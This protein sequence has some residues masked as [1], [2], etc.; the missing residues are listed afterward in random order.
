ML[1]RLR[2][3]GRRTE[4]QQKARR[5]AERTRYLTDNKDDTAVQMGKAGHL[6]KY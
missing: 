3:V 6:R 5:Q 4:A 1:L 2:G